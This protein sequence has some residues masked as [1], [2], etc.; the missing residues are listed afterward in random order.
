MAVKLPAGTPHIPGFIEQRPLAHLPRQPFHLHNLLPGTV[1]EHLLRASAVTC[2]HEVATCRERGL[3]D[4]VLG[5][6]GELG[7]EAPEKAAHRQALGYLRQL[8]LDALEPRGEAL[9]LRPALG[10]L[11]PG[12]CKL[13]PCRFE[14][15]EF[16][17]RIASVEGKAWVLSVERVGDVGDS[18]LVEPDGD[19]LVSQLGKRRWRVM[20]DPEDGWWVEV[21]S[22][23]SELP[24]DWEYDR[25]G[26]YVYCS[27]S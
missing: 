25:K 9:D 11:R 17:N 8:G 20:G 4:R 18:A 24:G 3:A 16:F 23:G 13:L 10:E 2:R 14:L 7:L 19:E 22:D 6:L 21:D 12:G 15:S 5:E 27:F 1:D 26:G